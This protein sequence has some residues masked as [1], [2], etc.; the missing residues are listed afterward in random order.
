[1]QEVLRLKKHVTELLRN[2]G[3][4]PNTAI[5]MMNVRIQELEMKL[6]TE[7]AVTKALQEAFKILPTTLTSNI[8][9]P[10]QGFRTGSVVKKE[11]N[12]HFPDVTMVFGDVPRDKNG[13]EVF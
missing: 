3:D 4:N 7:K 5:G 11:G 8:V 12:C 13:N 9:K 6:E 10:L 2:Y 1:M